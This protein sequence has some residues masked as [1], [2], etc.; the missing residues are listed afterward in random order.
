MYT[1]TEDEQFFSWYVYGQEY[2]V[3]QNT[4][5]DYVSSSL[6]LYLIPNQ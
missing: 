1:E 2:F 4:L 5:A 6:F 3:T